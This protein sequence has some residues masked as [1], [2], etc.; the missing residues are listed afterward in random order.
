MRESIKKQLP[1]KDN[2][3]QSI[4]TEQLK[5]NIG[6]INNGSFLKQR[7]SLN[8]SQLMNKVGGHDVDGGANNQ[9][10]SYRPISR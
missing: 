5:L 6:G 4:P 1:T 8:A 7:N 9:Q 3:I 10:E 2:E